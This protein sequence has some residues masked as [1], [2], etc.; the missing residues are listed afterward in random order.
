MA[1]SAAI[2]GENEPERSGVTESFNMASESLQATASPA[3]RA[4]PRVSVGMPAFNA[5]RFI[6]AAI[7]SVLAQTHTDLELIVSDNAS[8]DRTVA[9]CERYVAADPR[10]RLLRCDV[11]RGAH[12]NYRKVAVAARGHYFKWAAAND[13]IAPDFLAGCVAVLDSQPDAVLAFGRTLLFEDDPL[14]GTPYEDRMDICDDDPLQRFRRC[15]E[16]LRLNN[17]LNGVLRRHDL[18]NTSLMPDYMN[19]DVLVLAE[20]SLAG[21]FVEVPSTRFY[22]RMSQESATRLQSKEA[23][24]K[25]HYPP[26][27]SRGLFQAWRLELGYLRAVMRAPLALD[28]RLAALSYVA[29]QSYWRAGDLA[30]DF[31]DAARRWRPRNPR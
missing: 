25:H 15:V 8:T 4:I 3:H 31:R 1:E 29:R 7:E 24:R 9:I 27:A 17:V 6:A 11:N 28:K 14:Q 13:L 5:E 23:V 26:G 22:R 10:V 12:P 2:F 16:G 19:A 20:L 30:A 21:K 18:L